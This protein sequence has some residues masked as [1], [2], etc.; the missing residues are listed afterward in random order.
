MQRSGTETTR[1]R[2]QPSKPKR[3]IPRI[4]KRENSRRTN[5]QSS[6]LLFSKRWPLSNSNRTNNDMNTRKVERHRKSDSKT[7]TRESQQNYRLRTVSN[8]LLRGGLKLVL[9]AQPH[10]QFLK[11]YKT[12]SW[13]FG[14]H[15]NTLTRQRIIMV[16]KSRFNTIKKQRRGLTDTT[17]RV[18]DRDPWSGKEHHWKSEAK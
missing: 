2:I 17:C 11:W 4:T 10:P 1:T 7:G 5:G 16:N 9:R 8:E 6:E 14:S 15:D 12:F 18:T 3:E 13:L